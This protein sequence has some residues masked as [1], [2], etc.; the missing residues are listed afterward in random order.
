[1]RDVHL[2]GIAVPHDD[3]EGRKSSLLWATNNPALYP[4]L[5]CTAMLCI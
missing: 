5:Y 4:H 2:V 3:D 1:M